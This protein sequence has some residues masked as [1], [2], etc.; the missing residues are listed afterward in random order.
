VNGPSAGIDLATCPAW[1]YLNAK[2]AGY[3]RTEWSPSGLAALQQALGDLTLAEKLTLV[4][5]LHAQKSRTAE[6]KAILL[7]L[8]GESEPA[9]GSAAFAALKS[10]N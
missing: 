8:S 5:D 3:Y 4:F 6:A 9:V 7:K 1:F 2:G 10:L